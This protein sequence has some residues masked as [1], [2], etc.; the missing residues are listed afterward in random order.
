[1]ALTTSVDGVNRGLH[2][3]VKGNTKSRS[4]RGLAHGIF[5]V[6]RDLA[7]QFDLRA[8]PSAFSFVLTVE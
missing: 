2:G 8:R 7:N 6:A 4:A 5:R 1:M 3:Q